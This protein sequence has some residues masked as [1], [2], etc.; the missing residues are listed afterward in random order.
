MKDGKNSFTF[1]L[2]NNTQSP[3][4]IKEAGFKYLRDENNT[5]ATKVS[6]ELSDLNCIL[7]HNPSFTV[8]SIGDGN[9]PIKPKDMDT[10]I[11]KV[12]DVSNRRRYFVSYTYS[13]E[14]GWQLSGEESELTEQ[15]RYSRSRT[16]CEA[17]IRSELFRE[18]SAYL[19]NGSPYNT[20]F[21]KKIFDISGTGIQIRLKI[22]KDFSVTEL[23]ISKEAVDF[24]KDMGIDTVG[25]LNA[26]PY[27]V[28]CDSTAKCDP[29]VRGQILNMRNTAGSW[30]GIVYNDSV[31]PH[32]VKLDSY[33]VKELTAQAV[34]LILHNRHKGDTLIESGFSST[35]CL[36][37]LL[38]GYLYLSDLA[39]VKDHIADELDSE[40][41]PLLATELRSSGLAS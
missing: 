22:D 5:I 30:F 9:K 24:L 35:L 29:I 32:R 12:T 21:L 36:A 27:N 25:E 17:F 39:P 2:I 23:P 6:T 37:L 33:D 7:P 31:R 16:T 11:F 4:W 28:M 19:K 3:A 15:I 38:K 41:L 1:T 14:N 34:D 13:G 20:A 8:V 18:V 26:F 10:V 40:D